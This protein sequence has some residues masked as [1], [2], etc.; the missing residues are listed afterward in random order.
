MDAP[1]AVER[2]RPCCPVCGTPIPMPEELAE[3]PS[4]AWVH[5]RCDRL[6]CA[7]AGHAQFWRGQRDEA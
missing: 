7:W 6:G 4:L 3:T 1:T 2:L 5:V